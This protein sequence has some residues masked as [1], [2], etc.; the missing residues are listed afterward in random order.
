M[1]HQN[2]RRGLTQLVVLPKGFTLIELLVVVL[3]IGILAAMAVPQYKKAVVK[4]RFAEAMINLKALSQAI[5]I[6]K[7]E[8]GGS[9]DFGG[10]LSVDIPQ[11]TE[12][13]YYQVSYS[14][15]SRIPTAIYKKE[16]VCLCLMPSG[17][18]VVRQNE[19]AECSDNGAT[20]NYA[21]LLNVPDAVDFE[22]G[23]EE[24]D[25]SCC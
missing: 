3:I 11:E 18:L 4:S 17:K 8:G 23:E 21:T 7:L 14:G 25:C 1:Q 6:C 24:R 22:R 2:A 20:L 16:D 15:T 10:S 9:C 12:N 19:E 5:K 13:F